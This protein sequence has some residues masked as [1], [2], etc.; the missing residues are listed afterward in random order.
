MER[1]RVGEGGGGGGGRA[2]ENGSSREKLRSGAEETAGE[3]N[4]V[5]DGARQ[6]ERERNKSGEGGRGGE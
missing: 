4:G 6:R 2:E 1:W 5:L 3:S